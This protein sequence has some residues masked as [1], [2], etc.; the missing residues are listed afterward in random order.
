MGS[1]LTSLA[2]RARKVWTGFWSAVVNWWTPRDEKDPVKTQAIPTQA[3][4]EFALEYYKIMLGA[5]GSRE[6]Q[7]LRMFAFLAP[8]LAGLGWLTINIERLSNIVFYLGTLVLMGLLACGRWH[9]LTMAYNF[10]SVMAQT[11]RIEKLTGFSRYV[12][13]VWTHR[14]HVCPKELCPE[15]FKA[16]IVILNVVMWAT[17]VIASLALWCK[18]HAGSSWGIPCLIVA[19]VLIVLLEKRLRNVERRLLGKLRRVY[20]D[21]VLSA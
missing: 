17:P 13:D 10:R 1:K 3:K 14:T 5:L 19:L 21:R 11:G 15:M 9:T 2:D 7:V 6:S 18:E 20:K 16:H 4:P 12:L 8:A